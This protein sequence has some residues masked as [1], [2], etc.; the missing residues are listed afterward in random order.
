MKIINV[1]LKS[2]MSKVCMFF[3]NIHVNYI[4]QMVA[5]NTKKLYAVN[6]INL[7]YLITSI[8][9]SFKFDIIFK[10]D[11][12]SSHICLPSNLGTRVISGFFVVVPGI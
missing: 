3:G 2:S 4:M 10:R 7:R 9:S 12:F 1:L 11:L 6:L 8:D 5:Q